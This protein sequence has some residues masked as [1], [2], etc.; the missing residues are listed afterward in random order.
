MLKNKNGF[1]VNISLSIF[2]IAFCDLF[3]DFPSY[4]PIFSRCKEGLRK[5]EK[6]QSHKPVSA[7]TVQTGTLKIRNWNDNHSIWRSVLHYLKV[8]TLKIEESDCS[9]SKTADVRTLE[10]DAKLG[11]VNVEARR[12]KTGNN[13]NHA[14][15]WWKLHQYFRNDGSH[16]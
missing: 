2:F 12:V 6:Y 1:Q 15:L 4:Y 16:S 3:T 14:I 11:S 13:G 9:R 10:V 7:P 5:W 8:A